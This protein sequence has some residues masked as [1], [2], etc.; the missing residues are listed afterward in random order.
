MHHRQL[1]RVYTRGSC[2][3]AFPVS[4]SAERDVVRPARREIT[5]NKDAGFTLIE[6]LVVIII[7]GILAAI[8]I[9]AFLSQKNKAYTASMKAD[10][11]AL[12]QDIE[13]AAGDTQDYGA[14][15]WGSVAMSSKPTIVSPATTTISTDTVRV[16]PGD[17][18]SVESASNNAYCI[19]A[20]H[21]NSAT[22]Y[23]NSNRSGF[24]TSC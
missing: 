16:S 9:P 1:P 14:I 13:A 8:A 5:S 3:H 21:A 18:I 22:L 24:G 2:L 10:L 20:A 12:I 23:Y 4:G 15:L 7:I 6:L 11:Q 19:S 17:T